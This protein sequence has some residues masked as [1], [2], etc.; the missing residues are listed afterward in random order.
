MYLVGLGHPRCGTGFTARLLQRSGLRVGHEKKRADGIV[1]WCLASEETEV[2][3]G[4]ALGVLRRDYDVFCV[5]RSPLASLPSIVPEVQVRRTYRFIRKVINEKYN[6]DALPTIW[7]DPFRNSVLSYCYWYDLCLSLRPDIIFRVD[8]LE[9]D[10]IL[11]EYTGVKIS[12][13]DSINKNHK[14]HRKKPQLADDDYKLLPREDLERLCDIADR[15]GYP[16]EAKFLKS[17]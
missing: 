7:Q 10:N 6:S 16:D 15:L 11:S 2:P 4:Q 13:T 5:A 14:P 3:W 8:E 9:D 12:R 1:S 17:L